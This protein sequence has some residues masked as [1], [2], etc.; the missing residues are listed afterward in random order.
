MNEARD[1]DSCKIGFLHGLLGVPESLSLKMKLIQWI[2]VP[3]AVAFLCAGATPA[4]AADEDGVAIA[5]VYDTSGSMKQPVNDETGK[6]TP[7]YLIANR[8]LIAIA[9]RIQTFA[10]NSAAIRPRKIH[11]GLFVFHKDGAQAALPF[12]PFDAA[13]LTKWARNFSTPGVGTPLG[14]AV[15]T[16]GRAVSVSSNGTLAYYSEP[17]RRTVADWYDISGRRQGSVPLPP[18]HYHKLRLSPD[19]TRAVIV[20]SASPSEASLWVI[21]DL[22]RG[23]VAQLSRGPG[24]NET[25]VWSPDGTKVIFSSDRDGASDFFMKVVGDATPEQP[26]YRSPAIFKG[27][28]SWSATS[29]SIIFTQID[30][31]SGQNVYRLAADGSGTVEPI[32][33]GPAREALGVLSPDAHWMAFLSDEAGSYQLFVQPYPGPGP[34][35]QISREGAADAWWSADSRQLL[36]VSVGLRSLWRE[37]VITGSKLTAGSPVHLAS[38]PPGILSVDLTPDR[39]RLLTLSPDAAASG[40]M[41]VVQHW[42]AALEKAR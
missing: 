15:Y 41:A 38:L 30:R 20:R 32:V 16:A 7:K 13:A 37:D 22:A 39:Q 2:M 27:P 40:A 25:P 33:N 4:Y 31:G 10:T 18:G 9:N 28:T 1:F 21:T 34:R 24:V 12:G 36:W 6:P 3:T 5:I 8:A 17:S 26:F 14:N 23:E 11:A 29:K 19:G 35:V 42:R